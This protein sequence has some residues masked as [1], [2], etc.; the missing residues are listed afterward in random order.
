MPIILAKGARSVNVKVATNIASLGY[1][2]TKRMYY[3]GLKL[4]HLNVVAS[5][6]QLPH[7][8]LS[9]LS[10]ASVHDYEVFRNELLHIARNSKC[11][12]DSAYYDLKNKEFILQEYNVTI[13]AIAKRKRGQKALF[14]DQKL[15]NTAISSVRQPIEG[16]FN[17]LI[18]KTAIQNASKTRATKGVLSHVYGKIAAA[19]VFLAIFN[20]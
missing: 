19:T 5:G 2:A 15:Q 14:Y 12:L 3:H 1:C 10:S 13:C 11:Y 4:H 18:E 9:T 20:F 6:K 7:P 16:F 8:A 17:W